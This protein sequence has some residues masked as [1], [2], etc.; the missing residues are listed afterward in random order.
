MVEQEKDCRLGNLKAE[1]PVPALLT[2][3]G[4]RAASLPW[5]QLLACKMRGEGQMVCSLLPSSNLPSL[6]L[7]PSP[8]LLLPF[9][10]FSRREKRLSDPDSSLYRAAPAYSCGSF[11]TAEEAP[12]KEHL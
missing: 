10:R 9:Q 2:R 7:F 8:L 1:A 12:E 5:P 3:V 4:V 11:S 6:V